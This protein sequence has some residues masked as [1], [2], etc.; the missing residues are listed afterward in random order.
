MVTGVEI[1]KNEEDFLELLA[2]MP[3]QRIGVRTAPPVTRA[4]II[5]LGVLS[6]LAA[7][8]VTLPAQDRHP[9]HRA[10]EPTLFDTTCAPCQ[11][12]YRFA[13][14]GWSQRQDGSRPWS[15]ARE[16]QARTIEQLR[17]LLDSLEAH[18]S[19]LAEPAA[20]K[21]GIFYASCKDAVRLSRQERQEADWLAG[22]AVSLDSLGSRDVQCVQLVDQVL[23]QSVGRLYV[24]RYFSPA[25]R[26]RV[27]AI[28]ANVKAA[29]RE[30]LMRSVWLDSTSRAAA[31][32][33][34]KAM[35]VKVGYPDAWPDESGLQITSDTA[36]RA[37]VMAAAAFQD[38]AQ[39]AVAGYPE[40]SRRWQMV[41]PRVNAMVASDIVLQNEI[42]IPAAFLQ[43]P[44]FDSLADDA[45]NYGAIGGVIGHQIAH[46]F[47]GD[48]LGSNVMSPVH[49][50]ITDSSKVK[51]DRRAR[52]VIDQFDYIVNGES[53]GGWR[54]GEEN[55]ADLLGLQVAYA[56]FQKS[57][58]GKAPP[59]PVGGFT[60]PQR[61]FLAWAQ[62]W[63]ENS[64]QE[65]LSMEGP[66]APGHW[67]TD[68]PL[69]N[70][71]AFT[72]AW[73]CKTG[74]PMVRP[75]NLRAVIW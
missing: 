71:L 61:F 18:R 74:T 13:T 63:R 27:A 52:V 15:A 65:R 46:G 67:R 54:Y 28:A 73:E 47:V 7:A 68:G 44:F 20:R 49:P 59:A 48:G 31:L 69:S 26:A 23:T 34:L 9:A 57:P 64:A 72:E 55:L 36:Y 22:G 1:A 5:V 3:E 33:K 40:D 19:T 43:P 53:V 50:W 41:I 25:S 75:E 21:V 6:A 62:S 24:A 32:A 58:A 29:F 60:P 66:Y 4:V 39:R 42:V 56:A 45:V 17:Q 8:A 14:G 35:T 51:Y 12:F 30:R 2:V 38:G 70:M 11:D 16:V 37:N 10:F